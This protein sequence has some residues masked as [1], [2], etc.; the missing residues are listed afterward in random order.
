MTRVF[1]QNTSQVVPVSNIYCIGRNY[2]AHIAELGNAR[3]ESPVVF[4]KPTSALS[5]EVDVIH[6]PEFSNEV[7]YETEL[8]LLIGNVSRNIQPEK[9]LECITGYGIGLDLTARDLQAVA[10]K[11]GLPWTLAKGFNHAACVSKFISADHIGNPLQLTFHMKQNGVLRQ[12]GD[13]SLMLF[14]IP[15]IV[16]YLSRQFTLLPGDLIYTGTPEGVGRVK[17][18]DQFE[19]NLA[20]KL[21]A[22]FTVSS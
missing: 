5:L 11:N 9:A 13:V 20:N 22:L 15:A 4:L 7:D 1:F 8:V 2:A 12:A 18:G 6:L 14:D 3:P 16:S 17:K 10:K 21:N 19:L